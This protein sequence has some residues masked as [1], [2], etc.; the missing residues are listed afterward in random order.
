MQAAALGSN[1]TRLCGEKPVYENIFDVEFVGQTDAELPA[2]P[3]ASLTLRLNH[4]REGWRSFT[5]TLPTLASQAAVG[6]ITSANIPTTQ[7]PS[8]SIDVTGIRP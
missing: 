8:Y 7:S 1:R 6:V 4:I 2:G 5:F 3:T